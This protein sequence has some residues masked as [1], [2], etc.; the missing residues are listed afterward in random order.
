MVNGIQA[1]ERQVR[2][3]EQ[4]AQ[5][6]SLDM[7]LWWKPTAENYFAHVNKQRMLDVVAKAA[8]SQAAGNSG[9][10]DLPSKK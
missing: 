7:H 3:F 1:R 10:P 4:L 8:A 2:E 9:R 6:V 5:A